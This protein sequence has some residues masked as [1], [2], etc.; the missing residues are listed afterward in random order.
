MSEP[1][2]AVFLNC[3]LKPSPDVSNTEALMRKVI[4]WFDR[5]DVRSGDGRVEASIL[6]G[7]QLA[8]PWEFASGDG[9]PESKA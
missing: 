2:K 7:S 8:A 6:R 1:L 4:E 9:T 3:T 5:M